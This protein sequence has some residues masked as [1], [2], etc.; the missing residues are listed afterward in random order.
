MAYLGG[1]TESSNFP[2]TPGALDTTFNG[3]RDATVSA[4]DAT[5]SRLLYSTYLGGP[6][7]DW[8][9]GIAVDASG[10]A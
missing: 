1:Y 4:L 2:T 7:F 8:A 3:V 5:G 9:S 6:S 10:N